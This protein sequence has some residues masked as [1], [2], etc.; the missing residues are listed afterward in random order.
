MP[1]KL[2]PP[3]PTG[4]DPAELEHRA[5]VRNAVTALTALAAQGC[6]RISKGECMALLDAFSA[7]QSARE[8]A[9]CRVSAQRFLKQ[10]A[11]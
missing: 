11:A 2:V 10:G 1:L 6:R 8:S 9:A 5:H 4:N 3:V 7:F